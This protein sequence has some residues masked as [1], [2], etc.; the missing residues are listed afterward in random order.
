MVSH[1]PFKEFCIPV[2]IILMGTPV[3]ES[4]RE[5]INNPHITKAY[6]FYSLGD[7]IQRIDVQRFHYNC[8]KGAPFLSKREFNDTD[9][10]QQVC[11]TINGNKI[12]HAKYR[13]ILKYLPDMISQ[14]EE[15]ILH[16]LD[17]KTLDFDYA[18][19]KKK[20]TKKIKSKYEKM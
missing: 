15:K 19:A 7:W 5:F 20:R 10:V 11:L 9:N 14:V 13:S 12:G 1:L 6:S 18:I 2:E 17:S 3:Q 4:T 16:S 8:P